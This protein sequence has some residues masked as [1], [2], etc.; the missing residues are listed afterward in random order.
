MPL[1]GSTTET[2]LDDEW[3]TSFEASLVRFKWDIAVCLFV[4]QAVQVVA[5]VGALVLLQ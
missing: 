3:L 4:L 5:V 2:K 1:P